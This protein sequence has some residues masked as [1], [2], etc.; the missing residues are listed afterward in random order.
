[1]NWIK[2]KC[3]ML[4]SCELKSGQLLIEYNKLRIALSLKKD[5]LNS[6]T[7]G[8]HLY[9]TSDE[10][11]KEGDWCINSYDNTV[12]KYKPSPCPLPYWGNKDTLVKIIATTDKS[13]KTFKGCIDGIMGQDIYAVLPEPSAEFLE[14]Y[15]KAYNEGNQIEEVLIETEGYDH[16]EEWS[17]AV[18]AYDIFKTR[19]K[20]K[21]DNTIT[22][23]K[24]KDSWN[25]EEVIR[26]CNKAWL[27]TSNTP[28][29]L[30]E[31]DKWIE[32]NL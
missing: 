16:I 18:G 1:M 7:C 5:C 26:L 20:V 19:I 21:S 25:R 22:I 3:I 4:S 8:Q 32:Q 24:L 11:I 15:V 10:V 23:K 13:L 6:K 9:F 17:E 28:N 27:K 31:F 30:K 12:W 29:I 2:S 14:I